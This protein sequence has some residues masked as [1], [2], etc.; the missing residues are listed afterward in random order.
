MQDN[1]DHLVKTVAW[2]MHLKTMER[3][4]I[5]LVKT[6]KWVTMLKRVSF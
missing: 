3:M 1:I 2:P 4:V 6:M 5:Q